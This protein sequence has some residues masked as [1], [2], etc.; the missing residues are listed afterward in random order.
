LDTTTGS[1]ATSGALLD[2]TRSYT[3]SAWVNLASAN[4]SPQTAVSQAGTVHSVFELGYQDAGDTGN[5]NAF[6]FSVFWQDT[7]TPFQVTR[8]CSASALAT[9]TWVHLAGVY[10]AVSGTV[11]LYVNGGTANGG[12]TVTTPGNKT[13]A[14][15]GPFMVGRAGTTSVVGAP[16][17]G[18]VDNVRVYQGVITDPTLLL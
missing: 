16:F 15:T 17:G 3:V 12:V 7:T 1:G 8:A 2:T 5:T 4:A 10:D 14:T 6:C 18:R 13:F 11:T 9:N